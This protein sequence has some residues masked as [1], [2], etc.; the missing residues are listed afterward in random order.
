VEMSLDQQV[1]APQRHPYQRVS[2]PFRLVV[3]FTLSLSSMIESVG[4]EWVN[5]NITPA[6]FPVDGRGLVVYEACYF[7][8]KEKTL[9]TEARIWIEEEAHCNDWVAAH[10]AHVLADA[11]LPSAVAHTNAVVGLGSVGTIGGVRYLVHSQ[12][13]SAKPVLKIE[14]E[15][16]PFM[17]HVCCLAVRYPR[18]L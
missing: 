17:A 3:D 1:A 4:Y 10:L 18:A 2:K 15:A 5:G 14:E 9:P 16:L 11:A 7:G 6:Y 13:G 8:P 12:V